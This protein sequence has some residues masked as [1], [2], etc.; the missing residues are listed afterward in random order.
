MHPATISRIGPSRIGAVP[1]LLCVF[2]A[3]S[4]LLSGAGCQSNGGQV[5][6]GAT[7]PESRKQSRVLDIQVTR[8]ETDISFTNTTPAAIPPCRMWLN[9]WYALDFK[10]LGIGE[11]TRLDLRDFKDRYGEAFHGGGFFATEY[12][13][14]LVLAQFE[15]GE[16][17][18]GLIVI[19]GE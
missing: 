11:S 14:R 7:F 2:L 5:A 6:G 4:A 18:V 10:G 17:L 3:A 19:G 16:E 9:R 13:D 15:I 12:P 8:D 1:S